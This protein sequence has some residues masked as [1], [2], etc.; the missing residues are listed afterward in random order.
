MS[1]KEAFQGTPQKD[2]SNNAHVDPNYGYQKT[3]YVGMDPKIGLPLAPLHI[4]KEVGQ[5]EKQ[6]VK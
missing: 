3:N 2:M 6:K 4:A 5:D 1:S